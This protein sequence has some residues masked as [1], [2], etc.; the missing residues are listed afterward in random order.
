MVKENWFVGLLFR[1]SLILHCILVCSFIICCI[2]LWFSSW[3]CYHYHWYHRYCLHQPIIYQV[4]VI[5]NYLSSIGFYQFHLYYGNYLYCYQ[6]WIHSSSF[7]YWYQQNSM[8]IHICIVIKVYIDI[9]DIVHIWS[10]VEC[11]AGHFC[12]GHSSRNS[13]H[14]LVSAL[15]YWFI[16]FQVIVA[17]VYWYCYQYCR[18]DAWDRIEALFKPFKPLLSLI[19]IRLL[20]I[21]IF[22]PLSI[23]PLFELSVMEQWKSFNIGIIAII[24]IIIGLY[25]VYIN[26]LHCHYIDH[27]TIHSLIHHFGI[28]I[29]GI[30]HIVINNFPT[31]ANGFDKSLIYCYSLSLSTLY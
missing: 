18:L 14:I 8:M 15:F 2:C 9:D 6:H 19:C 13:L 23:D 31:K 3:N 5:D 28:G 11:Y 7:Y 16:D 12:I 20:F 21:P 26:G 25:I 22:T 4:I 30:D 10:I 27:C 24:V 1:L 29:I 17:F